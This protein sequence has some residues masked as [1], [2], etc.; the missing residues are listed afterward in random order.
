MAL[1]LNVCGGD[2]LL[3]YTE[4]GR[5]SVIFR[6]T[7]AQCNDF[8]EQMKLAA[9]FASPDIQTAGREEG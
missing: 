4:T 7:P 2:V 1:Q 8:A 9:H 5:D 3:S 6:M